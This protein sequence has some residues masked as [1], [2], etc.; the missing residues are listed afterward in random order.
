MSAKIPFKGTKPS[1]EFA[2]ESEE[3]AFWKTQDA[4][5]YFDLSKSIQPSFVNLRSSDGRYPEEKS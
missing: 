4:T 3:R 1:P 5:E 2:S